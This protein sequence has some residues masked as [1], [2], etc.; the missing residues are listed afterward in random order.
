MESCIR[1]PSFFY[2]DTARHWGRFQADIWAVG[3]KIIHWDGRR[4]SIVPSPDASGGFLSDVAA[5]SATNV[6]AVGWSYVGTGTSLRSQSRIEHWN[7]SFWSITPSPKTSGTGLSGITTIS[8]NNIWAVG[9]GVTLGYK[10]SLILHWNG[11]TWNTLANSGSAAKSSSLCDITAVS[12]NNIWAVGYTSAAGDTT[13]L[14]YETPLIL[15]WNGRT[16]GV[17]ASPKDPSNGQ[18]NLSGIT[19]ISANN[20]WAVGQT[21]TRPNYSAIIEYW[22]GTSWSLVTSPPDPGN[23]DTSLNNIT[24]V[25]AANIWTVGFAQ[26]GPQGNFNPL[27]ERYIAV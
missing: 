17:V 5:V 10:T 15:H 1:S 26:A 16:W 8:A 6:W 9:S 19:A 25:S 7:G 4:W 23:Q 20:I 11:R 27:V 14:R 12:A 21:F 22:D 24:A 18:T 3:S 2:H 13:G